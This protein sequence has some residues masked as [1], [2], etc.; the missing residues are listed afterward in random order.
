MD[1][2][3]HA[4]IIA[5]FL[6]SLSF[7]TPNARITKNG[8]IVINSSPNS[9]GTIFKNIG[10][11]SAKLPLKLSPT[12][13]A[14]TL[15]NFEITKPATNVTIIFTMYVPI[16]KIISLATNFL[17]KDVHWLRATK[18]TA[19]NGKI[20]FIKGCTGP[21][22]PIRKRA[23]PTATAI[24]KMRPLFKFREGDCKSL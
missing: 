6:L 16:I 2:T 17:N 12:G 22:K 3:T 20:T 11:A 4:K 9:M 23:K 8:S 10:S 24:R 5:D 18:I 1:A 7:F 21:P 13:L 14:L 15:N 19:A